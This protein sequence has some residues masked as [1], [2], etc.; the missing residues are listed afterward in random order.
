MFLICKNSNDGLHQ[1]GLKMTLSSEEEEFKI[2]YHFF[3][4]I[5]PKKKGMALHLKKKF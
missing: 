2:L 3:I 1:F 5:S 4:I